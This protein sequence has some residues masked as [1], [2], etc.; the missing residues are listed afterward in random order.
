LNVCGNLEFAKL[1]IARVE[2]FRDSKRCRKGAALAAS[3]SAAESVNRVEI[4]GM[5]LEVA[6]HQPLSAVLCFFDLSRSWQPVNR[7]RW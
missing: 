4:S 1:H 3:F 7:W 2:N 6:R 5:A